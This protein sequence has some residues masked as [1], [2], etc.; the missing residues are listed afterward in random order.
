[1]P[2]C[3]LKCKKIRSELHAFTHMTYNLSSGSAASEWYPS[4]ITI[5]IRIEPQIWLI[6]LTWFSL[7]NSFSQLFSWV[8]LFFFSFYCFLL[9]SPFYK[10][11]ISHDQGS[12]RREG[13]TPTFQVKFIMCR[14]AIQWNVWN[15]DIHLFIPSTTRSWWVISIYLSS[16]VIYEIKV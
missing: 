10:S 16:S 9:L 7:L 12:Y 11:S 2:S 6:I 4:I 3:V 1:M 15:T 5:V 14:K 13:S 8:S